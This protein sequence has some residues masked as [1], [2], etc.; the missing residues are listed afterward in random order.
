MSFDKFVLTFAGKTA[1]FAL[2]LLVMGSSAM[3]SSATS[4]VVPYNG[5]FAFGQCFAMTL[6]PWLLYRLAQSWRK[7]VKS[8]PRGGLPRSQVFYS[9]GVAFAVLNMIYF[10][11]SL[12]GTTYLTQADQQWG[13]S[14]ALF[15]DLVLIFV[16]FVRSEFPPVAKAERIT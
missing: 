12:T 8:C 1:L 11:I 4:G 15:A 9:L 2:A 7:A 5:M 16:W 3:S 6:A 10:H 13:A 14:M